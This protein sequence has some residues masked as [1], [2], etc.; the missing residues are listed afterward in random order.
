MWVGFFIPLLIAAV[1]IIFA[2]GP[3][4][5]A[6]KDRLRER[7]EKRKKNNSGD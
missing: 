1:W 2:G 3:I 7:K 4:A 6:R 5:M